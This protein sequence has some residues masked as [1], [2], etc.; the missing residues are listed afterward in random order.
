VPIFNKVLNPKNSQIADWWKP[1]DLNEHTRV[2]WKN[3]KDRGLYIY[4]WVNP[5]PGKVINAIDIESYGGQLV[6]IIVAISGERN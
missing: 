1:R 6:P 5:E 4:E 2:G 3:S